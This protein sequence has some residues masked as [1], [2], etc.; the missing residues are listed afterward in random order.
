[1]T[2]VDNIMPERIKTFKET[3]KWINVSI[4]LIS[5]LVTIVFSFNA[6]FINSFTPGSIQTGHQ[7]QLY[8]KF[9]T[10]SIYSA[11]N[12]SS[13]G[14]GPLSIGTIGYVNLLEEERNIYISK[15]KIKKTGINQTHFLYRH[16]MAHIE[17]KSIVAD[18]AGGYPNWSNPIRTAKY[19]Y[20]LF[21]LDS[22]YKKVMPK[23][24]SHYHGKVIF[25]GLETAADCRALKKDKTDEHEGYLNYIGNKQCTA[26]QRAIAYNAISGEWPKI[27]Q[28]SSKE[29]I[30]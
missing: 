30:E 21:K 26:T 17:Q 12:L 23:I 4:N 2:T 19:I 6:F 7:S 15:K 16:E 8:K 24:S 11:E 27:H 18:K 10:V 13:G 25:E 20:Y 1:M 3:H 29:I 9:G 22:D 14:L 5:V 28:N